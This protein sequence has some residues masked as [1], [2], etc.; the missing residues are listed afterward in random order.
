MTAERYIPA[1]VLMS[2]ATY[3]PRLLPVLL[4]SRRSL[5]RPLVRWLSCIP[6]AVLSALLGPALLAPGGELDLSLAGN[7]ELWVSLPVFL[8]AFFTRNLFITVLSGMAAVA[9]WRLFL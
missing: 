7:P 1:L 8:I 2:L 3:L 9:L 5:P 4:L 6:V